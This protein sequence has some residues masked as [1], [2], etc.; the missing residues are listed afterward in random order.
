MNRPI[1]NPTVF[2]CRAA[3]A[4]VMTGGVLSIIASGGGGGGG[5][6]STSVPFPHSGVDSTPPVLGISASTPS[7]THKAEGGNYVAGTPVTPVSGGILDMDHMSAPPNPQP[8]QRALAVTV[9]A[10][11]TESGIAKLRIAGRYVACDVNG[12]E[13]DYKG[14]HTYWEKDYT[15]GATTIPITVADQATIPIYPLLHPL[16]DPAD[17]SKGRKD[18]VAGTFTLFL[19]GRNGASQTPV[20]TQLLSYG[21]GTAACALP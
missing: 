6:G 18:G 16:K 13:V 10:K 8:D 15:A 17:P 14:N 20:R 19:E 21:V 9:T 4:M 5:S 7:L 11:D 2:L 3:L 1:K 12:V